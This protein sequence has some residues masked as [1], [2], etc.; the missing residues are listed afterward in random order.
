MFAF[1]LMMKGRV[2][3][4]FMLINAGLRQE[5]PA[6]FV[7]KEF[8]SRPVLVVSFAMTP[9]T[10]GG[11][12]FP[13]TFIANQL[14]GSGRDR[15]GGACLSDRIYCIGGFVECGGSRDSVRVNF[16]E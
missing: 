12:E 1:E 14:G 15:I 5:F 3:R 8:T 7:A 10:G 4:T 11:A 6:A 16:G 9:E 2:S 13:S